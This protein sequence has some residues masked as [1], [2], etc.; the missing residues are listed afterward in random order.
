M[1]SD[2]FRHN[3]RE[4][5][6]PDEF[7]SSKTYSGNQLEAFATAILMADRRDSYVENQGGKLMHRDGHD[8]QREQ[9]PWLS[10]ERL[11]HRRKREIYVKVGTP[12][13]SVEQGSFYRSHPSGV[14]VK[15]ED[16]VDWPR[17]KGTAPT[18]EGGHLDYT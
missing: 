8:A 16:R 17:R 3:F 4:L 5:P 11:S 14:D 9:Y 18:Y 1:P 10:P 12:D 13:P 15:R 7:D 6:D 2:D